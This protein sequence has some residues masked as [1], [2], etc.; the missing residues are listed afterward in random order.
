MIE[1]RLRGVAR[2]MI[3]WPMSDEAAW[4]EPGGTGFR[5]CNGKRTVQT[6]PPAGSLASYGKSGAP[7]PAPR[8]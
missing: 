8:P 3:R 7:L 6:P 5:P 2:R 4:V 1:K